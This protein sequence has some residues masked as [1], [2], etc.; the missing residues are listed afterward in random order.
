MIVA[1][2]PRDYASTH[3][4]GRLRGIIKQTDIHGHKHSC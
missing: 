4:S 1:K 2:A 3:E